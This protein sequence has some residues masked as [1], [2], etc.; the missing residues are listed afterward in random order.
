MLGWRSCQSGAASVITDCL[1]AFNTEEVI[2]RPLQSNNSLPLSASYS[3]MAF[4]S[5][6]RSWNIIQRL[7]LQSNNSAHLLEPL[8]SHRADDWQLDL[9]INGEIWRE[10]EETQ[11][12]TINLKKKKLR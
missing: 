1:T 5:S 3:A 4:A 11:N 7:T 8:E 9:I 10:G 2:R 6:N 12:G